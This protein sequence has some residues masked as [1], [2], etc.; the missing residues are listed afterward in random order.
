M[1][2]ISI[3]QFISALRKAN[4]MTQQEVAD[5]L[6]VSNKAV[7]RWERDECAP[8]IS[9]IPALAEMFGVTCDELLRGERSREGEASERTTQKV[10]KQVKNI[11]NRTLSGFKTLIWISMG[12]AAVGLICMF[13]IYYGFHRPVIAFS[14]MLL[15]EA[16]A[17][18]LA[19]LAVSR[20]RDAR[21]DN[22]LFDLA[23]SEQT[24]RFDK[25][26]AEL[27]FPAFFAVL[28]TVFLSLFRMVSHN[29]LSFILL[30]AAVVLTYSYMK[31]KPMYTAR[32]TGGEPP[33]RE[34]SAVSLR[35][36]RMTLIQ[37]GL[38]LLAGTAF[39]AAPYFDT[40][41]HEFTAGYVIT[42]ILGFILMAASLICFAVFI[43]KDKRREYILPGIR[44]IF[45]LP[46]SLIAS[47]LHSIY[48][49]YAPYTAS[50]L[51]TYVRRDIWH[52]ASLW[53]A[54]NYCAVVVLAF[55]AVDIII[56]LK[57]RSKL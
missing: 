15:F 33:K 52:T 31:F 1:A 35:C 25:V 29:F 27:S 42:I 57:R 3:G 48:W 11:I 51:T 44:N 50:Q 21:N 5:R 34:N 53:D 28:S 23:S 39:V 16:A 26:T 13:G 45:L 12:L 8:D 54:I 10:D 18:T 24:A 6:N 55:A 2:K 40:N 22:E 20:A 56:K 41:Y 30:A 46:A 7:S 38:T 17:A 4:G 14:V 32:L 47:Q 43:L 9:V 36:R 49:D 37:L 19:A